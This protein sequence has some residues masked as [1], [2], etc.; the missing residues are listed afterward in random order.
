MQNMREAVKKRLILL[1]MVV[2][3]LTGT[4]TVG[5][6]D[7]VQADTTVYVTRTGSKYHTH[8]CGN[9][10]YYAS[11]RS[12]ALARGLTPCK[13]CFPNGDSVSSVSA[14]SS[15]KKV[16]VKTMKL[17]KSALEMVKGQTGALKVSDAP[18]S[19]KWSSGDSSIVSVSSGGKLTA[20]A[21]GKTTITVTSGN[22]KKQCIVKVEEPKLSKTA[23]TMDLK[24]VTSLNLLGCNHSVKW[25][26][27]D[28]DIVKVKD[29]TLTAKDVGKAV[30]RAKIHGK[31]YSCKVTVEKPDVKCVMVGQYEHEMDAYGWQEVEIKTNP[32]YAINYYDISVTSSDPDIVSAELEEVWDGV[33]VELQSGST[34]GESTITVSTGRKSIS[35]VVKVVGYE[36][37][38]DEDD[39]LDVG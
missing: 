37:E 35:F 25:Y 24:E 30:V 29:G 15:Y 9:G 32:S 5:T 8:K 22:Q 31:T 33:Y 19:I 7:V 39:M 38:A 28:S 17:N 23:I 18:E 13:K 11:S 4:V 21:K 20:K 26:S 12:S 16:A 1:T 6:V 2:M 14:G 27:S 3:M 36:D 34:A 10:T